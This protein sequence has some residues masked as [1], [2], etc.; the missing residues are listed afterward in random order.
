MKGSLKLRWGYRRR[1]WIYVAGSVI[2]L[3]HIPADWYSGVVF[4]NA[5]PVAAVARSPLPTVGGHIISH[6]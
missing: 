2:L 5:V 4:E 1:V 6:S 3:R